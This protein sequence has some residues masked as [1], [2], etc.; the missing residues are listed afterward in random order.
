MK[1]EG[2]SSVDIVKTVPIEKFTNEKNKFVWEL[3]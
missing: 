2:K 3:L 1:E